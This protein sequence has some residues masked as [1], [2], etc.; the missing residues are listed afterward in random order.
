[1][2]ALEYFNRI[3]AAR[4][5]MPCLVFQVLDA[6]A[7][8]KHFERQFLWDHNHSVLFFK[9]EVSWIH[10]HSLRKFTRDSHGHLAVQWRV[11]VKRFDRRPA[12]CK[13]WKIHRGQM[14]SAVLQFP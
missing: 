14:T 6:L 1:M 12:T 13:D 8:L 11:T 9:D 2:I 10:H 3:I 4:E 7:L 5:V